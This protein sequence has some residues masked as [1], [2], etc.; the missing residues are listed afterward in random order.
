[1][2]LR[3]IALL[4]LGAGVVA[5][6]APGQSSNG[7]TFESDVRP[8]LKAHCFPC[9]GE[10]GTRKGELDLRLRR[11]AV[12]GGKSGA[13]LVPGNATA[14]LICKKISAGDMPKGKTRLSDKEIRT[15]VA[16]VD[17]GAKTVR[18]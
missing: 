2:S 16:W 3:L 10:D 6:S 13:A 14:S 8:I 18:A 9:H 1:M 17:G 11:S 4:V 5:R 15:I 12:K 7:V